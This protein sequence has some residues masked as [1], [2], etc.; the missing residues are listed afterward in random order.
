MEC[1]KLVVCACVCACVCV[2][3]KREEVNEA[4][5]GGGENGVKRQ[6]V[7][8]VGLIWGGGTSPSTRSHTPDSRDESHD[9]QVIL[10]YLLTPSRCFHN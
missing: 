5:D 1:N 6:V 4:E 2:R 9:Q 8:R 10:Y 3:D 7:Q